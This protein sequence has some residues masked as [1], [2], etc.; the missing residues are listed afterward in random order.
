MPRVPWALWV[1]GPVLRYLLSSR[2]SRTRMPT[3][4]ST[5]RRP[6]RPRSK[7]G[8]HRGSRQSWAIRFRLNGRVEALASIGPAAQ[9]AVPQLIETLKDEFLYVR[10]CAAG[11]LGAPGR[12]TGGREALERPRRSPC[13]TTPVGAQSNRWRQS[14]SHL[15]P[16]PAPSVAPRPRRQRRRRDPPSTGTRRPGETSSGRQLGSETFGY[17]WLR[18]CG[19]RGYRQRQAVERLSGRSGV[20]MAFRATDGRFLQDLAREWSAACGSSCC[21][22]RQCAVCRRAVCTTSPPSASSAVSTHV[23][24]TLARPRLGLDMRPPGCLS[25]RSRQQR[26]LPVGDLLIVST[27]GSQNEGHTR[28]P[29]PRARA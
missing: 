15:H 12:G 25:H 9:S 19:L 24:A 18:A 16:L 29:T 28:V 7:A 27:N 8:A 10:I 1:R 22:R 23:K 4:A 21:L 20:L 3:P 13:V 26:V 14:E 11:A 2:L 5:R 17:P 6:W